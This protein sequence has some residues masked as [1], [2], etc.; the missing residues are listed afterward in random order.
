MIS[1]LLHDPAPSFF[2][3]QN[4]RPSP[5]G[6]DFLI[7][8]SEGLLPC[9]Y[10]GITCLCSFAHPVPLVWDSF[11]LAQPL[12]PAPSLLPSPPSLTSSEKLSLS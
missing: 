8:H 1:K 10:Y 7:Q 6:T 3:L 4:H 9:P 12:L 2:S 5:T 11:T